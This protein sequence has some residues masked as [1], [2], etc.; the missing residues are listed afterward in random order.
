MLFLG[1]LAHWLVSGPPPPPFSAKPRQRGCSSSSSHAPQERWL[2]REG[3]D[4]RRGRN[5]THMPSQ[6]GPR[7]ADKSGAGVEPYALVSPPA[8][9]CFVCFP[10]RA[11]KFRNPESSSSGKSNTGPQDFWPTMVNSIEMYSPC[12][13]RCHDDRAYSTFSP[14]LSTTTT[15]TSFGKEGNQKMPVVSMPSASTYGSS[16]SQRSSSTNSQKIS[17]QCRGVTETYFDST[18]FPLHDHTGLANLSAQA[19]RYMN[20]LQLL[21]A[22]A[23]FMDHALASNRMD[24]GSSTQK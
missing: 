18:V 16:Q 24:Q 3:S 22:V 23:A 14:L 7:G 21:L 8:A 19:L 4:R 20:P 17:T 1:R 10:S 15:T 5:L 2:T 12:H 9:S 6:A 13:S 11:R